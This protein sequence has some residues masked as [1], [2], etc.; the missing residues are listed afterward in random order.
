[1]SCP[2]WKEKEETWQPNAPEQGPGP[3]GRWGIIGTFG[4]TRM[5]SVHPMTML[6]QHWFPDWKK[7]MVVMQERVLI[8][9]KYRLVWKEV[10][11][12]NKNTLSWLIVHKC[13]KHHQHTPFIPRPSLYL[14]DFTHSVCVCVYVYDHFIRFPDYLFYLYILSYL[15][16]SSDLDLFSTGSL[17]L[18]SFFHPISKPTYLNRNKHCFFFFSHPIPPSCPLLSPV[19]ATHPNLPSGPWSTVNISV[20]PHTFIKDITFSSFYNLGNWE[21]K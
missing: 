11:K 1:M 9:G 12:Q 15:G 7:C 6:C 18:D 21:V 19:F 20:Y 13:T 4:E 5:V 17:G 16:F 8:W 14:L 2:R 10:V 3:K